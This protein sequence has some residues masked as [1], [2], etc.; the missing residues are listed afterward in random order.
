MA[1]GWYS[2]QSVKDNAQ[3][4]FPAACDCWFST[5]GEIIPRMIQ[6]ENTDNQRYTFTE[7]VV[8]KTEDVCFA[9]APIKRLHCVATLD[10]IQYST[11]LVFY[12]ERCQ[13]HIQLPRLLCHAIDV[14]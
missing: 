4:W 9:G 11:I 7:I 14:A 1:E 3:R 5:G 6:F 12:Q 10:G 2:K 13:W 8:K